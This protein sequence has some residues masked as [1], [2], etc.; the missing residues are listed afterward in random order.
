MV[1]GGDGGD[2]LSALHH[3]VLELAGMEVPRDVPEVPSPGCAVRSGEGRYGS[4]L[5]CEDARDRMNGDGVVRE[6]RGVAIQVPDRPAVVT[7]GRLGKSR[8]PVGALG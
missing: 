1:A 2:R 6:V 3:V 4:L 5:I 7:L 8:D